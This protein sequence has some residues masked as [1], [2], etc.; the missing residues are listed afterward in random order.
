MKNLLIASLIFQ[1]ILIIKVSYACV[2]FPIVPYEVV[3]ECIQNKEGSKEYSKCMKE[4]L[5]IDETYLKKQKLENQIFNEHSIFLENKISLLNE[6][7]KKALNINNNELI[8]KYHYELEDYK[9]QAITINAFQKDCWPMLVT[10]II[11]LIK[12]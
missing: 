12:E 7:L 6:K 1:T 2:Q 11:N 3:Y 5:L 4:L 8:T 10:Q 9:R